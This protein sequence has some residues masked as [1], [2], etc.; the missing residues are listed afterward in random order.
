MEVGIL[1]YNWLNRETYAKYFLP[2]KIKISVSESSGSEHIY[3]N[4]VHF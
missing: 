1:A 3:G 4:K 2:L